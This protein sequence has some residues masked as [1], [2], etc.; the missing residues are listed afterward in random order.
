MNKKLILSIF[1]LAGAPVLLSAAGEARL[2]RFPATNGKEIVFSYAGDLYKV[3]AAG[4]EAQRLTSHVGYE[5]FP[6]FSPDGKTIA[7]TGQ[8]DG[9]TE[10]YTMPATGG[11]PLRV[12]YTA[13]NS[14]DDL[15][16]RMGPNNIV[17]TWTPDGQRIVYRNR[18]SDGFSGK[19][20]TVDKEGGLSE[21]IPLPEGGFC[22][23]SP[24]GK[25]LAY[26]RV[27]REFRTWKYYKGG[28]ADDIWVYNP[29]SK[30]VENI[31]NNV[32]QDIFPMWIGDEIFFLSDRD[33]IMNI[34]VY[35]TKTKQTAKV[36]DFTEYDVKFPSASGNTIV[37]ENGGYIYKMDAATR[38]AEKVN[39]TLASDNI[40]ARTDL[41]DGANYV[42]AA[43]LS[44]D[45]ARMVVTS[46]GE[47][48]NLPV[49]KG[50]TKN[51]TRSPGAHDRDA[52][53]S[54]DGTQIAYIS[55]A[56]GETELYLQNAAGGEPMQL[57]HKNDTYI[58]GFKWSPDSKKIVYM[59]RKNRVN[60]LDVASGKVSLLLQDPMGVPGGVTFSPD[61]E[62]LTYTRMGKN[63][64]NVVYVYNI[65]EKKEYPVTDKWY[66]SSSPVF[67]AD[68]KYLIFSSARDFNPTYGS[69]EWNHVYNNMYGVYIALLSKDTS[70]PF[71]QKDA[72]VAASNATPKSGDKKPADKKEV[73]DTS[74][75]KFDPDGI[76]DRIVRL[77]LSPSYYGNFYSDGNKVYYWGR[78]GTKMYDLAS[79]KE[80]S[81]AD[82]ASMD[83][84]Y[85]GKKALFFKGRQIYVT[86]L[87]SGKTELTTPVNLSNM[88]ITVDYPKEWA[89]IFDE[90][91][92]AYR[93]GFYQESMHGVD[94]KAIKEK[95]AVLLPY[96]KTRLDLNYIIGEMI[97][98]LNCGHAYVN[99]G[100]TE[101]PKRINTGL[102]GAEITRDKSGFFRLE[103]IFP[104][105]SWSKELRSPL[106]EPGVDVKVGEYIV[107][108]DGVPTNTV[109]DMYSLLVG[110][111]EIPT[112]ISLNA[113]PQLS[114][115]RKVVVSP[116][117]NEYPLIH[118]N[119]VQD[120]IKKVDQASN[121]RIGYIYI[122]DMGP[123][124]L[125]E[126]ARYFYPQ[127]DKEGLIIDDRAN[128]GGNV[129]P[130]ILE[131]LSR[132]P[133]R[134]TM[135]RGTSHV[136]TVPDAVQ[137]GP[138][139]CLINKYSASDGD[140]FPWGFRALGL[141]KLIGTRTWGGI[142]GISGSLPY[143]DGTD[144]RVPFFTSYDPKTGQWII[145]NHGVDP[146][147]LI[148]NDPVKE[149]NGEDQ[150]LNRAIEEVMKQLQD[151]KPLAPVPAP[152]DFS[153]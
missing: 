84:T 137:V 47:V 147:I 36:T 135:G 103:K 112:E 153:K 119:W 90:A 98:E 138:K 62:W 11:E 149:W 93:D 27:M 125:N 105:A 121:G 8:Y 102:L 111:A 16:D 109:K 107:A 79:Q 87:P 34:F 124:G 100:E 57:T 6:R 123:E 13:T 2:L 144:I 7:F 122:P 136:G 35:N 148:D 61:S 126:F 80:E 89:Q 74:L 110:K 75:V 18:I 52:Q 23:Y 43:S 99:P 97:G 76:T 81:I 151:R 114:G 54:P 77:P 96:V 3:P 104:G 129:S 139:V 140:L 71:M 130:M 95:Y 101:Q 19:L 50:V 20:F 120:N 45:G 146:D 26:N 28:M 69:L 128:G 9:N 83:V 39:I 58:R 63:E 108:I 66:N 132:E 60:L 86:N 29:N 78:G 51:I 33:R 22:S 24:D 12:T 32:A 44:P 115:A 14:R 134:L 21:A 141:G 40:Y 1:V 4:G 59:D 133:Y 143:M 56:T 37:F 118:Y 46:R 117:A 68:G 145:E 113:K 127:L 82:G 25:Q 41:K 91:W 70:S 65:A 152:R 42:T 85:D 67:S 30:T 142:V 48:F 131:R 88:K 72:E 94:W 150:Q 106:T 15:G 55:D 5:M 31:T 10:V 53:W 116:L 73:A 17:M 64:I 92:R 38:K 49:E